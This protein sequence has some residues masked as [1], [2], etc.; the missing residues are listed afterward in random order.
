MVAGRVRVFVLA[1]GAFAEFPAKYVVLVT[2]AVFFVAARFFAVTA[3]CVENF[4][5]VVVEGYPVEVL[6]GVVLGGFG[7]M[8]F[9]LEG[10]WV[11]AQDFVHLFE[12]ELVVLGQV[13]A[14]AALACRQAR[15]AR[16]KAFAVQF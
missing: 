13:R 10:R 15:Q 6:G 5:G 2:F 12:S 4:W 7:E 8:D 9:G 11:A 16:P 3:F 14:V 1:T